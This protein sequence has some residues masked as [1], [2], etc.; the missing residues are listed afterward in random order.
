M[1]YFSTDSPEVK[2]IVAQDSRLFQFIEIAGEV[3]L[4]T[5][6]NPFQS[7]VSSIVEQQ[8]SIKAASAIYGR[9]EQLV[10]G[11]LEKPE[12]LYRVSDEALRQAGVSKRKIEYIR[13]VCE[14]VESGRLDF[15]ELEGAEATT[16]IEK[17]TAIKGIGQWTAEMFMMFSLGRLDVLSVGDVGLQRGAKW[18]YGN[19][20]GDGKKLLI[21]HGKAWAPYETVACLYLWKAAGTFAEEYRSLEELLHHGNQC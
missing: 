2:T 16:V 18:L 8:L 14:H 6:P 5:K 4:P 15:T 21:Y 10:G 17:L 11:A 7:L 9:V 13:H 19:G 20:E 1:R 12:Q 3:Q